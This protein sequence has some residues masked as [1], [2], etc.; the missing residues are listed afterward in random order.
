MLAVEL[1][2]PSSID[3]A[4]D[5][6]WST[7]VQLVLIPHHQLSESRR[8]VVEL[9][10]GMVDGQAVVECRQSLLFYLLKH[11]G[12]NQP[13]GGALTKQVALKNEA[14]LRALLPPM[15]E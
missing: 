5:L 6:Y 1:G 3:A 12:F 10:Y 15:S 4:S 11:L 2:D 13:Q 7:T 8:R 14:E 9:D